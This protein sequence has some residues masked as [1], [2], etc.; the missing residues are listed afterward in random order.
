MEKEF[1]AVLTSQYNLAGAAKLAHW[2]SVG[3]DFYHF[4][5]LFERVYN[6]IDEKIDVVAEQARGKGVEI[7]A[8]IFTEVPE[9]DWD[10]CQELADEVL[11]LVDNL[12]ESLDEL[13]K[14]ADDKSEYGILNVVEDIMSDVNSARYLL[15]S[16]NSKF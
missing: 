10:T 13:H 16:V 8:S 15:G 1:L 3:T 6:M 7:T 5:L 12:Q 14:K 2:N 9:I 11:K 4:H